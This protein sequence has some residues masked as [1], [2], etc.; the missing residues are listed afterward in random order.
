MAPGAC[1]LKLYGFV[2]NRFHSK[3][4]CW[5]KLVEV[6]DDINKMIAYYGMCAFT[7]PYSPITHYSTIEIGLEQAPYGVLVYFFT[8]L[9]MPKKLLIMGSNNTKSSS[10]SVIFS[11][12]TM[13]N[14]VRILLLL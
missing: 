10:K 9:N 6:T 3:L 13:N 2:I 1:T 8:H 12:L 14:I 7:L 11:Y 4:M 5:S